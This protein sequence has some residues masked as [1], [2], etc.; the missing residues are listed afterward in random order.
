MQRSVIFTIAAAAVFA[1]VHVVAEAQTFVKPP[2]RLTP[3]VSEQTRIPAGTDSATPATSDTVPLGT[4]VPPA[5]SVDR[6]DQGTR[7]AAARAAARPRAPATAEGA[8]QNS[9]E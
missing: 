6:A 9:P 7:S 1:C 4:P 5:G 3:N 8:R 2:P